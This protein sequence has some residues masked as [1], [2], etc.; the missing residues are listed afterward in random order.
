MARMRPVLFSRTTTAP[1]TTGLTRSSGP[2]ACLALAVG[3]AHQHHVVKRKFALSR[4]VVDGERQD[5]TIGQADPPGLALLA[6][7]LLH[8]DRRRPV[9]VVERQSRARQRLL[10]GWPLVPG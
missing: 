5:A 10:P 8:D 3:H 9:D 7:G 1:C 6:S 4:C 2:P